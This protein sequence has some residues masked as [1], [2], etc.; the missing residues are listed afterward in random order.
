MPGPGELSDPKNGRIRPAGF[1]ADRL[2][3]WVPC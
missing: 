2:R 1:E 3:L